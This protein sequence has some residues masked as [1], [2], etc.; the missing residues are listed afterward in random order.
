[1]Y[2]SIHICHRSL[3]MLCLYMHHPSSLPYLF[4]WDFHTCSRFRT[5]HRTEVHI[6]RSMLWVHIQRFSLFSIVFTCSR[7]PH[8]ASPERKEMG[9]FSVVEKT[10]PRSQQKKSSGIHLNLGPSFPGETGYERTKE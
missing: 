9:E 7:C 2:I 1:M 10:S 8:H 3:C 4:K 6:L 5:T